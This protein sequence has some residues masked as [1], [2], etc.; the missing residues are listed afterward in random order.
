MYKVLLV[1]DEPAILDMERR[2]IEKQTEDFS[3]VGEAYNVRQAIR[4]FEELR[5]DVVLTD[6]KMPGENGIRLIQ[7]IG[8]LEE[9]HTVCVSVSGYSDFQ[10]VHDA[11]LY[12]AFDYLLKPVEPSKV[13]ELFGRIRTL[14]DSSAHNQAQ[15]RKL[16]RGRSADDLVGQID[17]YIQGNLAGDNSIFAICSR[18]GIS[19]PYLSK[20]FKK[21][22][23]ETYNEYLVNLRI[24]EAGRLLL[25]ERDCLIGDIAEVVGFADQFYFSK[26]FKTVTGYTPREYRKQHSGERSAGI[27]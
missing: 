22:R 7:H 27:G 23:G 9:N 19:Q 10:Y 8:S 3:V 16:P 20:I 17:A 18:F 25:C 5:P 12:G 11:F 26:V 2:A 21:H 4:L 1:D 14:L 13:R 15:Q 6:I 24:E